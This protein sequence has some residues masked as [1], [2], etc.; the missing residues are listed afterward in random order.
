MLKDTEN[1]RFDPLFDLS[2]TKGRTD[3]SKLL[4][5]DLFNARDS[6]GAYEIKLYYFVIAE[7]YWRLQEELN[8]ADEHDD[9][10]FI[11]YYSLAEDADFV[12]WYEQQNE[13]KVRIVKTKGIFCITDPDREG[14]KMGLQSI[15]ATRFEVA[16]TPENTLPYDSYSYEHIKTYEGDEFIATSPIEISI[17]SI[18]LFEADFKKIASSVEKSKK[19]RVG[20][21]TKKADIDVFKEVKE[22]KDANNVTLKQTYKDLSETMGRSSDAIKSAYNRGRNHLNRE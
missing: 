12:E 14:L 7:G 5:S 21:D 2:L 16:G 19:D 22:Y 20:E 6:N 10:S 4:K 17:D 1:P 18:I 13:Y 11:S 15:N 3:L 8:F 9:E